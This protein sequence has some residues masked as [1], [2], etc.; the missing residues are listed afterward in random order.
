M[1]SVEALNPDVVVINA[2]SQRSSGSRLCQA[3]QSLRPDCPI[4]LI[5]TQDKLKTTVA[6]AT[7]VMPFTNK[8]LLGFI[9]SIVPGENTN[10]LR[11][12][13][14]SLDSLNNTVKR[15]GKPLQQLTPKQTQILKYL[16]AHAGEPIDRNTLFC[17]VWNTDYTGDTRT[18]DV[19]MCTLRKLIED[20]PSTPHFI[21]NVRGSGYRFCDTA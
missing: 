20:D 14:F 6:T 13:V 4:L 11:S 5:I 9:Q 16:M 19:H 15:S 21:T 3:I 17:E 12:G 2:A 7:L 8:K 10:K 18:L 1:Q